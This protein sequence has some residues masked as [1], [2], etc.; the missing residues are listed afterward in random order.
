MTESRHTWDPTVASRAAHEG[1]TRALDGR[2]A[3]SWQDGGEALAYDTRLTTEWIRIGGGRTSPQ[4]GNI[5][6]SSVIEEG[7]E[8]SDLVLFFKPDRFRCLK[9]VPFLNCLNKTALFTSL[10][11]QTSIKIG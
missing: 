5:R 8:R 10:L 1:P 9:Y 11:N 2:M 6:A 7:N 4:E 3:S